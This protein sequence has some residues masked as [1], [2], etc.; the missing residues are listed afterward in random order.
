MQCQ[1]QVTEREEARDPWS[2]LLGE[3]GEARVWSPLLGGVV[4]ADESS[5]MCSRDNSD[6]N[7]L[8]PNISSNS[9]SSSERSDRGRAGGE[10]R[11]REGRG[12][13]PGREASEG[14]VGPAADA[15]GSRNMVPMDVSDK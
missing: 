12:A 13:P 1:C 7:S 2:P 6:W 11:G 3:R 10:G 8:S 14:A 9:S 4:F 5:E 15:L